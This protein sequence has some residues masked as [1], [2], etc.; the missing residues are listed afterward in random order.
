[1]TSIALQYGVPLK[2][3]VDKFSHTRFEPAGFTNN[4]EIPMAKSITDYVFR[5]LG[6]RYMRGET[7][8]PD[9]QETQ[10]ES[11]GLSP[12]RV[13]VAGGSVD[14]EKRPQNGASVSFAIV[15]QADAPACSMCGSIMVRNGACYKCVNCG[16]T[17]GCS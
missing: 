8:S 5:Y 13:A 9:E 11:Q 15:N 2:A 1:M 17:S 7:L 6:N 12:V 16:G 14:V 10:A 4:R 3:L